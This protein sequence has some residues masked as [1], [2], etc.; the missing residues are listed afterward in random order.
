MN[1]VISIKE[2]MT[3]ELVIVQPDTGLQDI[4]Q[5]FDQ[6]DFHHLPVLEEGKLIGMIS[7]TDLLKIV[8]L[9]HKSGAKNKTSII[10]KDLMTSYPL[11]LDPDDSIGLAA[12]IFLANQ[13]HAL[14]IVDDDELIGIVTV[15]DILSYAYQ[16]AIRA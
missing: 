14:P 6:Y 2:I 12:D 13:F 4:Q 11:T 16:T 1:Q 9:Q 5:L 7:K 15:H 3:K 10:A 8:R